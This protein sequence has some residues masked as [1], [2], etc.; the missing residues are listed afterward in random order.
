LTPKVLL[1]FKENYP[2]SCAIEI[3]QT[4][5]DTIPEKALQPHQK[6][7]L[8][9]S[10]HSVITHKIADNRTRLPYDAFML[11]KAQA[12]VVACYTKYGVCLVYDIDDWKGARYNDPAL[13]RIPLKLI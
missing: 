10:K 11:K 2:K 9:D 8:L 12:F 7:A 3:K 6:K 1:W 13:F 5:K 4:S